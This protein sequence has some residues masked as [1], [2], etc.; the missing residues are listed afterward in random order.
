L[1]FILFSNMY[2]I[3]LINI[4]DISRKTTNN[5]AISNIL[6]KDLFKYKYFKGKYKHITI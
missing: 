1:F 2:F 3:I 4:F 6:S 5:N